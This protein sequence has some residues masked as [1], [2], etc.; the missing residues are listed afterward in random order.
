MLRR[1]VLQIIRAVTVGY[2]V[3]HSVFGI[4]RIQALVGHHAV[5]LDEHDIIVLHPRAAQDCLVHIRL[6]RRVGESLDDVAVG[7]GDE[8]DVAVIVELKGLVALGRRLEGRPVL[9]SRLILVG[10][11]IEVGRDD[12][13]A[14]LVGHRVFGGILPAVEGAAQINRRGGRYRHDGKHRC[15]TEHDRADKADES[16]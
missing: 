15:K 5:I 7:V 16:Q 8:G 4:E 14:V 6:K 11:F 9:S 10:A 13:A 3:P 12:V 2:D 1:F